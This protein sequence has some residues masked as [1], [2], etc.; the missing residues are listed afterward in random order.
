MEDY[1]SLF[2]ED[3]IL[4]IEDLKEKEDYFVSSNNGDCCFSD[5][6]YCGF[7]P[8][9]DDCVGYSIEY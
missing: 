2:Y 3:N 1:S 8:A 9:R 5:N 7:C 4:S 6:F